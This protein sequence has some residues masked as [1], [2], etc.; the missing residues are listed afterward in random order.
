[1]KY[2]ICQSGY[3][4]VSLYNLYCSEHNMG[5]WPHHD[6]TCTCVQMPVRFVPAQEECLNWV[7][8]HRFHQCHWCFPWVESLGSKVM[9][10]HPLETPT[11]ETKFSCNYCRLDIKLKLKKDILRK[12]FWKTWITIITVVLNHSLVNRLTLKNFMIFM[13]TLK[14]TQ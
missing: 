7:S 13:K 11:C 14:K 3:S 5:Q 12:G 8:R 1:M 10:A 6:R 4:M 2:N 9:R